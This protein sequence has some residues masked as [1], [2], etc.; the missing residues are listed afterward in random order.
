[1]A[2]YLSTKTKLLLYYSLIYPYLTY[3]NLTWSS[4]YVTNLNSVFLILK[5]IVRALSNATYRA[6]SAPFSLNSSYL[7]FTSSVLSIPINLCF[8]TSTVYFLLHLFIS[9]PEIIIFIITIPEPP[10]SNLPFSSKILKSG[11]LCLPLSL[12]QSL[13]FLRQGLNKIH[14]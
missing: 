7:I 13:F 12:V 8:L 1:M 6:H 14:E 11:T 4:T 5:R 9:T 2:F 10:L 3:C